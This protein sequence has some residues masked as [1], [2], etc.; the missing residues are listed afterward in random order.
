[1]SMSTCTSPFASFEDIDMAEAKVLSL[2]EPRDD[3]SLKQYRTK[4]SPIHMCP[5]LYVQQG[6]EVSLVVQES[7]S[8]SPLITSNSP[9]ALA[10]A[11]TI[12]L[13][14]GITPTRSFSSSSKISQ[15]INPPVSGNASSSGF[16]PPSILRT[17]TPPVVIS[18]KSSLSRSEERRKRREI[19]GGLCLARPDLVDSLYAARRPDERGGYG[20]KV[21]GRYPLCKTR[22]RRHLSIS[23]DTHSPSP[24]IHHRELRSAPT[25]CVPPVTAK[26]PHALLDEDTEDVRQTMDWERSQRLVRGVASALSLGWKASDV[27]PRL[28]CVSARGRHPAS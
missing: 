3:N 5:E 24:T 4:I 8:P 6:P 9:R 10:P 16:A 17:S 27:L 12:P 15:L 14:L 20:L 2:S 23:L 21:S 28:M 19:V 11:P 26:R 25:F 1:M 18:G 22:V 13:L 7:V